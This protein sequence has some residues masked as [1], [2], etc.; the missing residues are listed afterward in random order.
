MEY[1]TKGRLR[2]NDDSHRILRADTEQFG[3]HLVAVIEH[4]LLL[5]RRGQQ[6]LGTPFDFAEE[7][8]L[9]VRASACDFIELRSPTYEPLK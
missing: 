3:H 2:P 5:A 9:L 6:V 1:Y 7:L 4:Q 8:V